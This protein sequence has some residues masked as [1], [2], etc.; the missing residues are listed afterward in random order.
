M[1]ETKQ[2]IAAIRDILRRRYPIIIASLVLFTAV[3]F[4]ALRIIEPKYDSSISILV[5]REEVLNPL[6]MYE[7]AVSI[8]SEDRLRSFNEIIYSRSTIEM[9]INQLGLADGI[10]SE[11][12][13]QETVAKLR[14]QISTSSR[15]SDSFEI[16]FRDTDPERAYHA[17]SIL[18]DHFIQTRL[19]LESRRHNETVLFFEGKLNELQQ[20]VDAQRTEI[21]SSTRERMRISPVDIS[22]LQSRLEDVELRLGQ[23]DWQLYQIESWLETILVFLKQPEP[24]Q[25]VQVLFR[26]PMQ[27]LPFG[28]ELAQVLTEY[29]R[30]RQQFTESYPRV[31]MLHQQ[32]MELVSRVPQPLQSTMADLS[33]QRSEMIQRRESIINEM[34]SHYVAS[35]LESKKQSDFGIYEQLYNE[36]KVKLEQAKMTRDIGSKASEQFIVLDHPFIAEKPSAPSKKMVMLA[37]L[38]AGIA[39]GILL[40]ALAEALDTSIRSEEDLPVSKPVIAFLT[41]GKL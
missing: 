13:R 22:M 16:I 23:L 7:M 3:G 1:D 20:L 32:V 41:D 2:I 36:M 12:Q 15:A 18:A 29:E 24:E 17:V 31:R 39:T 21:V 28:L 34:Q 25:D 5:Q 4:A 11:A 19:R 26:L 38:F 33:L 35:Q 8:A 40:A 6:V 37:A 30:S 10:Y 14:R 27:E 9:L